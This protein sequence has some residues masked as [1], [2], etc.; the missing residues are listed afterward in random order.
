M[1]VVLGLLSLVFS[2][3]TLVVTVKYVGIVMNADNRGEGGVL[4]LTA[5][6]VHEGRPKFPWLLSALGLAGCAF[7]YG[8]GTITPAV[9]VL[10]AIEGLELADPNFAKA[11]V[12]LSVAVLIALFAGQ[13]HGTGSIGKLFG[14][15]MLLWFFVIGALGL[16][17]ILNNPSVLVAMNPWYAIH[18]LFSHPAI[19]GAVA[20][21]VFLAVTGGEALYADLGHF[22]KRPIR[23][24]WFVL[25]W[26]ALILNY[27][28]QGALVLADPTALSDPFY[29]FGARPPVDA[30]GRLGDCCDHYCLAGGDLRCVLH[31]PAGAAIRLPAPNEGV[32]DL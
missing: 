22:G 16:R 17:Q 10:S 28:G 29:Y 20:A 32:A 9:S 21:A 1:P 26:P 30:A 19:G 27:F 2:A 18:F 23:L 15:I 7:F 6:V 24:A 5:L 14:P 3:I 31:D 12:P 13:R 11:V 25:V 8:D 4:A